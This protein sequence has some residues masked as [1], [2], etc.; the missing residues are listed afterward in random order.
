LSLA[1]TNTPNYIVDATAHAYPS[2]TTA[3]ILRIGSWPNLKI[4]FRV[5]RASSGAINYE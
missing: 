3:Y 5:G 4:L 2:E 1:H